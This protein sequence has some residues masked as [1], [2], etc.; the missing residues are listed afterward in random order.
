MFKK[1]AILFCILVAGFLWLRWRSAKSE[2][3]V[4]TT[5]FEEILR[6]YLTTN[7]NNKLA[8]MGEVSINTACPGSTLRKLLFHVGSTCN[9][10]L[11]AYSNKCVFQIPYV[12]VWSSNTSG[13]GKGPFCLRLQ[14]DGNLGVIDSTNTAT[15][16]SNSYNRGQGPYSL[17]LV[18]KDSQQHAIW[19]WKTGPI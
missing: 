3:W 5:S 8:T 14:T 17:N 9:T 2:K 16:Y 11:Y 6:G 13:K 1:C 12:D 15:W 7:I 18:I 4:S 19:S 10:P